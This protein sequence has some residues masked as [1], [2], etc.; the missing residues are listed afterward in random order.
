[1]KKSAKKVHEKQGEKTGSDSQCNPSFYQL[2]VRL[3]TRPDL[4][5]L[6]RGNKPHFSTAN[7]RGSY[8]NLN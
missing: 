3:R 8:K 5:R 2:A 1:M 4:W 7:L 6:S